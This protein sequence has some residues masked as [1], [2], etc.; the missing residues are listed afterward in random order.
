MRRIKD[1]PLGGLTALEMLNQFFKPQFS[2]TLYTH[3]GFRGD[4][5]LRIDERL[6]REAPGSFDRT[7]RRG[8]HAVPWMVEAS[9]KVI[10]SLR[11]ETGDISPEWVLT[12]VRW[13]QFQEQGCLLLESCDFETE[14]E[15]SYEGN[16]LTFGGV[17]FHHLRCYP[18]ADF[19]VG[20]CV[21]PT[22]G[23]YEESETA[24]TGKKEK[25][26][27]EATRKLLL[28]VMRRLN[29]AGAFKG[30][31]SIKKIIEDTRTEATKP[32]SA[33]LSDVESKIIRNIS[34]YGYENLRLLTGSE[35]EK[36]LHENNQ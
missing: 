15:I 36:I 17:Q 20:D 31:K 22:P 32:Q 34:K 26:Q 4:L 7:T 21:S 35:T 2:E 28:N 18:S 11:A 29:Q 27:T 23:K 6:C 12:A 16:R 14:L 13:G 1:R 33:K 3:N 8:A 10:S 25:K 9:D 5:P 19:A 24:E 30:V